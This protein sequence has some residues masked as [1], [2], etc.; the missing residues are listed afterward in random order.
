MPAIYLRY[1]RMVGSS[2]VIILDI[3]DDGGGG[4][5]L[6]LYIKVVVCCEE[7]NT[8]LYTLLPYHFNVLPHN[9]PIN[10]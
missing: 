8:Q 6:P 3:D 1:V 10:I 2:Y 5:G 4:N 7:A 9:Q